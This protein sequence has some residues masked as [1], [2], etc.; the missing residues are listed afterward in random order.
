MTV[1]DLVLDNT[2]N[3]PSATQ[4]YIHSSLPAISGDGDKIVW[5]GYL[6][7]NFTTLS[8]V[9]KIRH[10]EPPLHW[11]SKNWNPFLHPGITSNVWKIIQGIYVNDE[12]KVKQGFSMVSKCC[13]CNQ[14]QD[15]MAHLQWSCNLSKTFWKW[16]GNI[17]HFNGPISFDDVLNSA[18][19][20]S[21]I[22][23]EVWLTTACATLREL[24]FQKNKMLF[25][26]VQ[27]NVNRFRSMIMSLVHYGSYRMQ[28]V[29]WNQIYDSQILQF[30]NVIGKC[31][32]LNIIKECYWCGPAE[33][34]VLFSC[35]G[36]AFGNPGNAG[37]GIFARSHDFQVLGTISGGIGV[38]SNYIAEVMAVV[39]AIEWSVS[40]S[41]RIIVISSY[42]E[43]VVADFKSGNIPGS[44]KL[45]G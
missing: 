45:D 11:P 23:K 38:S 26:N 30:L 19:H 43:S 6:K 35:N 32:S 27:P 17:F 3:I 7:G 29:S 37:F 40:L 4:A 36:A 42:S 22:I 8:N 25:E 16:L 1:K 13:I 33:G 9:N 18:K 12:K 21:P 20:K 39:C 28:G 14:I 34:Y 15:N 44:S 10:R 41:C 24:W 2:W 5:S 31:T